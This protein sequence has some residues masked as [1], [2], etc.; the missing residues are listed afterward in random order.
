MNFD[1]VKGHLTDAGWVFDHCDQVSLNRSKQ[2]EGT[3][4][5]LVDRRKKEE[6]DKNR[7]QAQ[8]LHRFRKK[9]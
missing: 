9:T 8:K 6:R 2:V 1:P 4:G 3:L 5:Y 7:I